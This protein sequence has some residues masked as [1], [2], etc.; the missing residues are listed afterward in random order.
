MARNKLH[1]FLRK[2]QRLARRSEQVDFALLAEPEQDA[3]LWEQEYEQ[4]LFDWAANRCAA[5]F[6]TAPGRPSGRPPSRTDL[7]HAVADSLGLSV[8]AVYIAKSRVLAR[9][10]E[11]VLTFFS[12]KRGSLRHDPSE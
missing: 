8:G 5:A 1:T 6:K 12:L 9:L 11:Q 10:R 4:R 2:Q 3:D 7:R